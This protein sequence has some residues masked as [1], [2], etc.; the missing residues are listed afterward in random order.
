MGSI[1][2]DL[3][4][5]KKISS[6][7][8]CPSIMP[9]WAE[10]ADAPISADTLAQFS[11]QWNVPTPPIRPGS[12]IAIFN[13]VSPSDCSDGI[14]QPVLEYNWTD[15]AR[16]PELGYTASVWDFASEND[17]THSTRISGFSIGDTVVGDIQRKKFICGFFGTGMAKSIKLVLQ[18]PH[19]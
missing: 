15:N 7:K 12:H 16:D 17:Y 13:S 9:S 3:P 18:H 19:L 1:I 6:V 8:T 4:S 2:S 10:F 5:G 14:F 11:T